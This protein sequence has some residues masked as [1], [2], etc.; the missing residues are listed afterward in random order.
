MSEIPPTIG[1]TASVEDDAQRKLAADYRNTIVEIQSKLFDKSSAYANLIMVGGYAGAFTIWSYTR[2]SLTQT[3]NVLTALLLG[4]SLTVFV[5]FEVYKMAKSILHYNSVRGLL[6]DNLSI[7]EFFIR[8][9]EMQNRDARR[10]LQEGTLSA[11]FCL[12][13]CAVTA[14]GAM[15]ILFYNFVA[16]LLGWHLWP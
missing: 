6:N 14:I 2:H 13:I 1:V 16:V 4:F 7:P 8:L 9:N 12:I 15:M 5:L 10:S 3:G 11:G